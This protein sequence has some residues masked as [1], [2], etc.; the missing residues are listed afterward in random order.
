MQSGADIVV[1][2]DGSGDV[3]T[4][5]AAIDRAPPGAAQFVIRVKPGRYHEKVRVDADR[6]PITLV[7]DDAATTIITFDDSADTRDEHG[8]RLGTFLSATMTVR[9]DRFEA[10]HIAIENAHGPRSQAVA[11]RVEA[12]RATFYECRI[13]GWQ[14]T[15]YLARGAHL[16]EQCRIEGH[17]DFIFGGAAAFFTRC[18]IHCRAGGYITAASTPEDQPL[19]FAFR[20]CI[21]TADSDPDGTPVNLGRPW[22]PFASV[23]FIECELPDAIAPQGW[24]NWDDPW[25]ERTARFAEYRNRGPGARVD[26]RASWSKQLSDAEAHAYRAEHL[27]ATNM[28]AGDDCVAR[29]E[30]DQVVLFASFREPDGLDGLHL[31]YSRDGYAW[32][33]LGGGL[34]VPRAGMERVMRDPCICATPDGTFH[35]VWTTGWS[36]RGFGHSTSHDLIHWSDQQYVEIMSCEPTCLNVWAPKVRYE[37]DRRQFMIYWSSTIPGRYPGDELHPKRRNHRPHYTLTRDFETFTTPKV[38]FDPGH[39]VID[40]VIVDRP[41]GRFALVFKD[42]RVDQ[43]RLRVAFGTTLFGPFDNVSDP[44]TPPYSEGPTVLRLP[45]G[46]FLVYY[47]SYG[48]GCYGAIESRDL[49]RWTDVSDRITCPL[50][51]KHGTVF[52]VSATILERL[53]EHTKTRATKAMTPT[54]SGR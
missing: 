21:V 51:Q 33:D 54:T 50:G 13:L 24:S 16:F 9:A 32:T 11:L 43:R 17:V 39:S 27:L 25:R 3:R 31:A 45:D 7:G 4:V 2:A 8:D 49:K 1:A 41:D 29:A 5:Q 23:A 10:R 40:A 35:L 22:R 6:P 14:D 34:I 48:A 20:E 38:L 26:G 53:I 18:Q 37:Q 44:L 46:N 52:P 19:G 42:E 12:A 15:L 36:E 47:D 28:V 30:Q